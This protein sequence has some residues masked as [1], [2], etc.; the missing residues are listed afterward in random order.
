M[1]KFTGIESADPN[2][3]TGRVALCFEAFSSVT[4]ARTVGQMGAC[5]ASQG[6]IQDTWRD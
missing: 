3:R 4:I 6:S 5:L 1:G 2:R